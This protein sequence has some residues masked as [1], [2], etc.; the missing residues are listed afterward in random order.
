M[1]YLTS[2]M[3]IKDTVLQ[4]ESQSGSKILNRNEQCEALSPR[5]TLFTSHLNI[6]V[7]LNVVFQ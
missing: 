4:K 1:R 3:K 7:F 6:K 5:Q 2:V